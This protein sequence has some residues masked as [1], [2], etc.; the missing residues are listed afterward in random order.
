MRR[1]FILFGALGLAA[2]LAAPGLAQ[3]SARGTSQLT[4]NGIKVSVEYG[5]P[6]LRGRTVHDMLGELSPGDVW[7]LGADDS[8]TFSTTGDL[9][10]GGLKVPKG[11]YSLWARREA[12]G[13]WKLV[14][15]TQ[16]GQYGTE[17]D[18]AKDLV[19]A[20]LKETKIASPVE[21]LTIS[22]TKQGSGGEIRIQWG[23]LQLAADF[24]G[25]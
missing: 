4:L 3:D 16:H 11:D 13:A 10:F 6:V 19:A 20:P 8:T 9:D 22:L 2:I 25:K 12:S 14:F 1:L 7:R 5:R 21:E 17:H 24:K 18:P 15:N 23:D